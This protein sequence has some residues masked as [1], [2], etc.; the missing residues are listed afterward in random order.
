MKFAVAGSSGTVGQHT[1]EAL[2]THGHDVVGL[3][4]SEGVDPTSADEV[5]EAL[6]GVDVVIDTCN[7][8]TIDEKDATQFFTTVGGNLQSAG[9]RRGV[10]HLVTLSIVGI[11]NADFGYYRAKLA[12]E[13][14]AARG[15]VP[16]T[17]MRATQLHEFPAQLLAMTRQG[18]RAAVF[19]VESQTVAASAVADALVNLAV[20]PAQ[21]RASDVG[22]PEAAN[23]VELAKAF[24]A[25]YDSGLEV[26][27]DTSTMSGL[28]DGALLPGPDAKIIGP[29]Y[30]Q[31]LDSEPH[32]V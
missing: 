27:P 7:A 14:S 1:V 30:T 16:W 18:D 28:P 25:R 12:H 29:T 3:S 24:V 10:Q 6:V 20:R 13:E 15:S 2:R 8:S 5:A 4:R 31:W 22:G 19:D 21:G 26:Q 17:I 32:R 11:D 9:A 23:L